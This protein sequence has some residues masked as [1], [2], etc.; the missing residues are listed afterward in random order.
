[1]IR[2]LPEHVDRIHVDAVS[3]AVRE[4]F[5]AKSKKVARKQAKSQKPTKAKA[6]AAV[7]SRIIENALGGQPSAFSLANII[8]PLVMG[9]GHGL[10]CGSESSDRNG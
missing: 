1:M 4:E 8:V 2:R 10:T 5:A 7:L 6:A 3:R 9:R